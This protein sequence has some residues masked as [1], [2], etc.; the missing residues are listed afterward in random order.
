M[1][2]TRLAPEMVLV[3]AFFTVTVT[4]TLCPTFATCGWL[5]VM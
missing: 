1:R 3:P 4:G 5:V 2:Y